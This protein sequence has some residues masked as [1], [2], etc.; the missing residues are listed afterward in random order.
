MGTHPIFESDFDCLTEKMSGD[1]T[2]AFAD[3]QKVFKKLRSLPEN[4]ICFDC[5]IKNPT[6]CTIP[7]GAFVCL[8]CSGVHR[9]LGTHL[10]FIRSADL[11]QAW[12]W[13]QLRCMQVG[14]NGKARAFFRANGG[15]TSDKS[16]KYSSRAATLYKGKIAKLADDAVRKYAGQLHI[17]QMAVESESKK[18]TSKEDNF[19]GKFD[20]AELKQEAPVPVQLEA[21]TLK[22]ATKI[23]KLG[24]KPAKK[25]A[26][27][28]VKK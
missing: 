19:F 21:T 24:K 8:D 22:P 26:F 14:G 25:G 17:G 13:R 15:E 2:A 10:T 27:G 1:V 23:N 11:D 3:T 28:G 16:V 6:W 18:D 7:Y 9:S 12:T 4:K 5:P 20:N